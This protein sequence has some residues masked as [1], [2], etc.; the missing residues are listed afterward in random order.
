MKILA[1][2]II[3]ILV[4]YAL[5]M[6]IGYVFD[7]SIVFPFSISDGLSV[8]EYKLHAVRLAT[9]A[10]FAYFGIRYMF[11]QST[12]LF[13]SQFM[14]VFLFFLS[15]VGSISYY[16]NNV[17]LSEYAISLFFLISSIIL[18]QSGK[19]EFRSYFR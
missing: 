1:K 11:F 4:F 2:I 3:I 12:K 15:T 10:T 14:G 5:S 9:A 6:V 18:Y 19:P 16:K 13:P 7:K 8:P 17:D